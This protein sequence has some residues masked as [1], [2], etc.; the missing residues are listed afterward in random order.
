[1]QL[2]SNLVFICMMMQIQTKESWDVAKMWIPRSYG[3]I[4]VASY[5]VVHE[6]KGQVR[7]ICLILKGT[8]VM[9]KE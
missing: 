6:S 1:M 5:K 2:L 7:R 3:L 4:Y 9:I 8:P